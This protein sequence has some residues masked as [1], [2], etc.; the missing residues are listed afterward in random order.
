MGTSNERYA[1][2]LEMNLYGQDGASFDLGIEGYQFPEVADD[3]WDSNWFFVR[4]QVRCSQGDWTFRDPCL[5]TFELREL[6]DWL[7]SV[8]AGRPSST[9]CSFTEPNL[10][11]EYRPVPAASIVAR[12][13]HES[14]PPWQRGDDRL[15]GFALSFDVVL[16]DL[17]RSASQLREMLAMFPERGNRNG[18]A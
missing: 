16:N 6:A 15:G 13:T 3:Y 10:D 11:F 17:A 7:D 4:G 18:A 8:A 5:T 12:F 2:D 14:A 9:I 1:D